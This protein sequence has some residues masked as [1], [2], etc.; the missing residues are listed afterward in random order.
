MKAILFLFS[1]TIAIFFSFISCNK[2]IEII[3]VPS[4]TTL[5][6][7]RTTISCTVSRTDYFLVDSRTYNYK[8]VERQVGDYIKKNNFD[9]VARNYDQYNMEFYKI[10]IEINLNE[11]HND[12]DYVRDKA[13]VYTRPI[14]ECSWFEGRFG[15]IIEYKNG[16]VVK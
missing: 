12:R 9:S 13:M 6:T 11:I 15:G 16:K 5:D 1:M 4:L 10:S 14:S 2:K 7:L 8:S 3:S